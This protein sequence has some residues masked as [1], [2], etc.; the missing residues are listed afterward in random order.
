MRVLVTGAY[1]LIGSACL[2]RLYRDG[3]ELIAAGRTIGEAARRQPF[4]RWIAA[5]F[6][7]LTQPDQWLPLL[8]G[9]D[10]VVNC[11]GVLEQSTRDDIV[12]T[13][14]DGTIALFEACERA[15]V[16]RVVHVSAIG[17]SAEGKT[18]FA[19][20]KARADAHLTGLDLD[21]TIL[22]PALVMAP[23]VYGGTAM[24]RALAAFPLFVPG[25]SAAKQIQV[26]SIDDLTETI[27]WCLRA[28]SPSK[29]IWEVAHPQVHTLSDIVAALR[30]WLGF[31]PRP[32]VSVPLP[33]LRAFAAWPAAVAGYL[34]W[35]SPARPTAL[36]QLAAGVVGNPSPWSQTT[37]IKPRSLADILAEHP[38]TVQDRW[39]ARLYLLKPLA[40]LA[41]AMFW[42]ATGV[43]ALGPGHNSAVAQFAATGYPPQ[44]ASLVVFVGA[45]FDIIVGLLLL[46]RR[47]ARGVLKLMLVATLGYLLAGTWLAPQLWF[48]PLGPLLKIVPMLVGT[49]LT[50]AIMD[51]R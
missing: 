44:T 3:H 36:K 34:G 17:A 25:I 22:R 27:A 38:A 21:W 26:V 15:G 51:E 13:Q 43:N 39:F 12:R 40:I 4:A 1:G 7:R 48:D 49:A 16:R 29:V 2:A 18:D 8:E 47:L 9:V 46:V 31:A 24:L 5:D 14:V 35:R 37:G 23:A 20:T 19:R 32:V 6:S 11:V 30:G 45:W 28:G 50:L 42:V 33:I 10:A 41:L